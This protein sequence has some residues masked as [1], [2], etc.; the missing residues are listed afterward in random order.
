MP[1][2]KHLF[3]TEI[4]CNKL[5][6]LCSLRRAQLSIANSLHLI[7]IKQSSHTG[8]GQGCGVMHTNIRMVSIVST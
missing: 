4:G 3:D 5:A 6:A 7:S 2:C 8:I 1:T